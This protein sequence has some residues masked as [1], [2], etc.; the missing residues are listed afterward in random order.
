MLKIYSINKTAMAIE[1]TAKEC[2]EGLAKVQ[3][4]FAFL[5]E[6]HVVYKQDFK[7]ICVDH[8]KYVVEFKA[9]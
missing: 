5:G 3:K 2:E 9:D 8:C 4:D 6:M 7:K 1:G